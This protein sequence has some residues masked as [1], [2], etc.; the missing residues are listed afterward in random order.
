[1]V[2]GKMYAT[3][4]GKTTGTTTDNLWMISLRHYQIMKDVFIVQ[5]ILVHYF[6]PSTSSVP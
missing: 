6:E 3:R 2:K 5:I 1:M 4:T